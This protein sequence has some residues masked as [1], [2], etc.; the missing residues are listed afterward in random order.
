MRVPAIGLKSMYLVY[1]IHRFVHTAGTP[2]RL[3]TS[4]AIVSVLVLPA[5]WKS[6]ELAR[7]VPYDTQLVAEEVVRNIDGTVAW[8]SFGPIARRRPVQYP[9]LKNA[10]LRSSMKS[11]DFI[12]ILEPS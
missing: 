7:S 12:L 2:G 8:P 11:Y 3:L 1:V 4:A 10:S 5:A 9:G 6:F